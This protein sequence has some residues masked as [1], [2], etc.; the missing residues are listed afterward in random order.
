MKWLNF[1]SACAVVIT[2]VWAFFYKPG[3]DMTI[4]INTADLDL[5]V[6]PGDDFFEFSSGG[7][8]AAH[9]IPDDHARYGAFDEL[10]DATLEKV[11]VMVAEIATGEHTIGSVENKIATLYNMAMDEAKLNADGVRPVAAELAAIDLIRDRADLA[12]FLGEFQRTGSV[13]WGESVD[14][15]L[16]NSSVYL[17]SVYQDGIGLPEREYY[18]DDDARSREIREKYKKFMAA[19]FKH[20]GLTGDVAAVYKIEEE[21]ARAHLKKEILRDPNAIYHRVTRDEFVKKYGADFDWDAYFSARKIAP[22]FINDATPAAIEAAM[23]ILATAPMDD[24]RAFL[25]WNVI[26]GAA[27]YLDDETYALSFDFYA[28]ELTGVKS[29]RPRYKRALGMLD[30]VVGEAVG[31]MFVKKYFSPAHKKRMVDLVENLRRGFSKQIDGLEWMTPETK[32]R[33]QEKLAAF[34]AKIGYPDKFRDYSKLDVGGATYYENI[35]R[36]A[37]FDD[38]YVMARIDR[39]VDRELWLMNPHQVNAYYNPTTNEICFPAGILQPPFFDMNADDAFNYGAI[40]SVIGHEMT[41][42]FDDEGRKFDRDGNLSEWWDAES[43]AAFEARAAVM[44]KFFD[45]IEVAP[46]LHANGEFTLGENLADYGGLVISYTAWQLAGGHAEPSPDGKAVDPSAREGFTPAQRF[47]LAY[48][49]IESAASRP[50]EDIRRTKTDV[51]SLPRWRVNGILPHVPQWYDAFNIA[52][53]DKMY[54]APESR[55]QIW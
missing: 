8:R 49:R 19:M 33:A 28:R 46:G 39:P 30:G 27:A 42:G 48:G 32:K 53:G 25:K 51:H 36:A 50:E 6:R 1:L 45:A 54:I 3:A 55:V 14:E 16:K 52:P 37:E 11:R 10:H 4:G 12:K 20:F 7:W 17:F 18:F 2:A 43:A 21:M 15:V 22:K 29:P 31:E 13:L 40:G 26:G 34:R 47:F 5:A 41:H 38:D 35:L 44:K 9:P 23:K 24:I